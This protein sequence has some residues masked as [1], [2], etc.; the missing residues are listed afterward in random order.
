MST[1]FQ[2]GSHFRWGLW[3]KKKQTQVLV[4]TELSHIFATI[5]AVLVLIRERNELA[6]IFHGFDWEQWCSLFLFIIS[7]CVLC[8]YVWMW[9][10]RPRLG[11]VKHLAFL[12]VLGLSGYGA[13]H[14]QAGLSSAMRGLGFER[15][16]ILILTIGTIAAAAWEFW[17]N[18][19]TTSPQ[20]VRFV[21]G[22]VQLIRELEKFCYLSDPRK[23]KTFEDFLTAFL[24]IARDSLCGKYD[25]AADFML[26]AK[27]SLIIAKRAGYPQDAPTLGPLSL[28]PKDPDRLSA[29][30]LA[31]HQTKL[32]YLPDI[33][34]REAWI[35]D[36]VEDEQYKL[37]APQKAWIKRQDEKFHSVLCIPV[38]GQTPDGSR[39]K[40]GV[41]NFTTAARD[42]FV[43]RDFIMAECFAGILSQ[44]LSFKNFA[45]VQKPSATV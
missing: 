5:L 13:M 25:V 15:P 11:K 7:I 32:I 12:V 19:L 4:R 3:I 28:D 26:P 27:D 1:G 33:D 35:L 40:L 41:L 45:G 34:W 18:K 20:E 6:G 23:Q 36:R 2:G 9:K 31:F 14:F 29:A 22:M 38:D 8:A 37:A 10:M 44:A 42:P 24:N 21:N 17:G 43:N 16:L 39:K 30:T